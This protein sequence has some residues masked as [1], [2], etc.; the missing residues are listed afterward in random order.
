M[1][2]AMKHNKQAFALDRVLIQIFLIGNAII[3]LYP[4]L[5][6]AMSGFKTNAEI[7][8]HPFA[9]PNSWNLDNF[10]VIWTQTNVPRFLLNSVIVTG[11]SVFFSMIYNRVEIAL[12]AL[13]GGFLTPFMVS[14]GD[15][16]YI[17]LFSYL[18]ILNIGLTV[19]AYFKNWKILHILSFFFKSIKSLIGAVSPSIE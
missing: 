1:G 13:L 14:T 2:R 19:L 10:K 16:N 3:M 15:G 17:V 18:L 11:F 4:I 9:L 5:M 12:L 6:M 7:F 8:T